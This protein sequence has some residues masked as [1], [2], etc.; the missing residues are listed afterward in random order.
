MRPIALSP[1]TWNWSGPRRSS[2]TRARATSSSQKVA[3][4]RRTNGPMAQE[5]LLSLALES[6]S[7]LRPSKSRRLTSL[8]SAAPT[9]LAARRTC[10]HDLRLGI[11]PLDLGCSPIGAPQPTAD[12]GWALVKISA[13]GPMPTSRYCDQSAPLDQH[14]PSSRIASGEPGVQPRRSPPRIV[15][16]PARRF[17]PRGRPWPAPR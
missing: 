13:S 2:R 14:L 15:A 7:A 9:D 11:V 4:N 17:A 12:I 10:Q 5:A 8:P 6:S 16:A 1:S 3:S